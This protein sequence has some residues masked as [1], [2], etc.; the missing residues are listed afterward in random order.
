MV[1]RVIIEKK[2]LLILM[3]RYPSSRPNKQHWEKAP[4]Q[5]EGE[6]PTNTQLL[7]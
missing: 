4:L 6:E 7:H 2:L 5:G 3:E 1:N